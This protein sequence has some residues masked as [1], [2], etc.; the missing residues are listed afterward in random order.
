MPSLQ[1][2]LLRVLCPAGVVPGIGRLSYVNHLQQPDIFL[3]ERE[4]P[5]LLLFLNPTRRLI[6]MALIARI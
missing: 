3:H 1:D 6:S 2:R 4:E 5:R